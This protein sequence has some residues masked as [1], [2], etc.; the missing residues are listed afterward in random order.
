MVMSYFVGVI[1]YSSYLYWTRAIPSE[2]NTLRFYYGMA[3]ASIL[4]LNAL[5]VFGPS[6]CKACTVEQDYGDFKKLIEIVGLP[7]LLDMAMTDSVSTVKQVATIFPELFK[8]DI[9]DVPS[10]FES[11]FGDPT[12]RRSGRFHDK[13]V[14]LSDYASTKMSV[15]K[16][17]AV[18]KAK[19]P[20]ALA[21]IVVRTDAVLGSIWRLACASV[22]KKPCFSPFVN[23]PFERLFEIARRYCDNEK[24]K[25]HTDIIHYYRSLCRD[26]FNISE[27]QERRLAFKTPTKRLIPNKQC[28]VAPPVW[29][30]T[31]RSAKNFFV[32]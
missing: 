28:L 19:L 2:L 27:I 14:M 29:G 11:R 23:Y 18:R 21:D 6:V 24:A 32:L 9:C 31:K 30:K 3:A 10:V 15:D 4:G 25:S 8:T 17:E 12:V 5:E 7:S 13:R 20:E 26:E 22:K 1:R 16:S